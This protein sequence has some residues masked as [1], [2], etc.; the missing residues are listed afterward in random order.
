MMYVLLVITLLGCW[1]FAIP[2]AMF[3]L[4]RWEDY[5]DP[6]M[7][8]GMKQLIIQTCISAAAFAFIFALIGLWC[9]YFILA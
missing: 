2:L 4:S 1:S 7:S 5:H 6:V 3:A 8:P 9:I